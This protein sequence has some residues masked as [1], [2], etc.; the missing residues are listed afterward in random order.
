MVENV[1]RGVADVERDP[2]CVDNLA[3]SRGCNQPVHAVGR[4]EVQLVG[5]LL[6]F[7]TAEDEP[8]VDG[9]LAQPHHLLKDVGDL[10]RKRLA[11]AGCLYGIGSL[12]SEARRLVQKLRGSLES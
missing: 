10:L 9:A 8:S 2:R 3:S 1:L 4:A 6:R 12:R 7:V 5:R 11:V